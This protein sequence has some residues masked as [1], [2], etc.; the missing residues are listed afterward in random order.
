MRPGDAFPSALVEAQEN[1]AI[2]VGL[3]SGHSVNAHYLQEEITRGISLWRARPDKYRLVPVLL[4]GNTNHL[5][6]GTASLQW[7]D[8]TG[9]HGLEEVAAE[10]LSVLGGFKQGMSTP[11]S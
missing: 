6:Y 3:L 10:L 1:S 2:T 5:L 11:S 8:A 4:E 9:P 7:V